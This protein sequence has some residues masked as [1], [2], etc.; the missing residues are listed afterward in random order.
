M[1]CHIYLRSGTVFIP[2]MGRMDKGFFRD[3][4]PVSVIAVSD[5]D[6]LHKAIAE[7]IARGNPDVAIPKRSEWPKHILLKYAGV[8]SQSVL[9]RDMQLWSLDD[10]DGI[11]HINSYAK[12]P[13][14]WVRIS[15]K[16]ISFSTGTDTV[17]IVDRMVAILQD[18]ARD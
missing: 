17:A 4:E 2:T 14:G 9:E 1:D 13:N 6:V 7:T 16:R 10:E 12:G 15:E 18:A 5:T 11:A 3:V 8:K